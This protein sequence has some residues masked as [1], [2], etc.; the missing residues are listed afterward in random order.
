[1]TND[2]DAHSILPRDCIRSYFCMVIGQITITCAVD[3]LL[4]LITFTQMVFD[5]FPH[6]TLRKPQHSTERVNLTKKKT[7]LQKIVH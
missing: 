4:S 5:T 2:Y 7:K 6:V 1:M 3:Y